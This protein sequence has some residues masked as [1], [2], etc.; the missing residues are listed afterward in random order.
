MVN[1][2][3]KKKC[4]GGCILNKGGFW[5]G[6]GGWCWKINRKIKEQEKVKDKPKN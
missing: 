3:K 2:I 4:G 1:L 5:M 6:V